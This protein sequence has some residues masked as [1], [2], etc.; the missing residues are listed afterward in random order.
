VVAKFSFKL[1]AKLKR[2]QQKS[3]KAKLDSDK[4]KS[5]TEIKTFKQKVTMELAK[6]NTTQ[7]EDGKT[8]TSTWEKIKKSLT[9]TVENLRVKKKEG[10]TTGSTMNA[11]KRLKNARKLGQ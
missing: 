4:I 9:K 7:L 3:K 6:H 5:D 8:S 11:K 10:K 2:H 1:S